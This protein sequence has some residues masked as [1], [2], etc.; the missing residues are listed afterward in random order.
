MAVKLEILEDIVQTGEKRYLSI[1]LPALKGVQC[2]SLLVGTDPDFPASAC[3][4]GTQSLKP[5]RFLF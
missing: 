5:Q 3:R 2:V 1:A 4:H